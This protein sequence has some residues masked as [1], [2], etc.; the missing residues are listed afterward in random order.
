[1]KKTLSM[2]LIS[3]LSVSLFACDAKSAPSGMAATEESSISV[4][5]TEGTTVLIESESSTEITTATEDST[6][7]TTLETTVTE[8]ETSVV[9]E[10]TPIPEMYIDIEL[11]PDG[12]YLAFDYIFS[13]DCLSVDL[14][15]RC[16]NT[17][18]I[19][20]I[21]SLNE[22]DI[23]SCG[24]CTYR[25]SEGSWNE[26]GT[27]FLADN[28]SFSFKKQ[29]DGSF[30]CFDDIGTPCSDE[31]GFFTIDISTDVLVYDG[32]NMFTVDGEPQISEGGYDDY[33]YELS[34]VQEFIDI[35]NSDYSSYQPHIYFRVANGEI[36]LIAINPELHQGWY[37]WENMSGN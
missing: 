6:V 9:L 26:D 14:T 34:G 10:P 28:Y 4:T 32:V 37:D 18:D 36:V 22:N 27:G 13:E 33:R 2:V 5:E 12:D 19:N 31:L 29:H 1:M 16:F 11:L 35:V 17:F 30:Y 24:G 7:T 25:F 23:F 21:E 20:Y 3:V 8:S 15:A